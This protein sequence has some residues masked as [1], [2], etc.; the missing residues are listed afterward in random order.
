MELTLQRTKLGPIATLGDLAVNGEFECHTLEDKMRE[1]TGQ[2]VS[3]WKIHG[4]TA[5]PTGRY[6]V[7][8]DYSPH[9]GHPMPH[10]LN[11]PGFD[12]IRI[13]RGNT[14]KDTE[15][16]ILLGMIESGTDF[17]SQSAVAFDAFFPKLKA[18]LDAGEECWITVS[19]P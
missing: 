7:V 1:V 19:N 2:P 5:I 17:I 14:D 11:V 10:L 13:H 3:D 12:G 4:E 8:I 9:F 16:C 15:G 18:A 6:R